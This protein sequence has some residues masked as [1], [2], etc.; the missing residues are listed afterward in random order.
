[1]DTA[2]GGV[3]TDL[4]LGPADEAPP[5][6]PGLPVVPSL[7]DTTTP[8]PPSYSSSSQIKPSAPAADQPNAHLMTSLQTQEELSL[9]LA[10]M[11]TQLKLNALHFT[12]SLAKERAVMEG[13]EEKLEANLTR[14]KGERGRLKEHSSKSSS[15]TWLVLGAILVVV[16]AW[17]FM[18]LVIRIT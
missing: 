8:Y 2:A 4:L 17:I 15:T 7:S 11:A 3:T 16:I 14:L 13:A 10:Q 5:T 9:Q 1:M 18:F 6:R 12:E